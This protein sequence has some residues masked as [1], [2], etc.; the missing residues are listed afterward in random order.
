MYHDFAFSWAVRAAVSCFIC[1]RSA[2][3]RSRLAPTF[4]ALSV[5]IWNW[6]FQ[7]HIKID[8]KSNRNKSEKDLVHNVVHIITRSILWNLLNLLTNRNK[9]SIYWNFPTSN[10]NKIYGRF[11]GTHEKS[12]YSLMDIRLHYGPIWLKIWITWQLLVSLPQWIL[13]KSAHWLRPWH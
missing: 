2:E 9:N 10:F 12:I 11:Y 1:R 13:R 8:I 6:I 3:I 7:Y 5:S 4:L